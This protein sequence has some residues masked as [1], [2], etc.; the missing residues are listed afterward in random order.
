MCR[1]MLRAGDRWPAMTTVAA[2]VAA[3]VVYAG[4]LALL[5]GVRARQHLAA[6]GSS[7]FAGFTA[8]RSGWARVA[9]LTFAVALVAGALSPVLVVAGLIAVLG[10]R[11]PLFLVLAGLVV[12]LAGLVVAWRSQSAM[13]RSWRIG[14]DPA[15]RTELVTEGVFAS[16]R[17]PIF[18]GMIIAQAGVTSMAPTWLSLVGVALLVVACQLQV[19]LVEEPYL[20]GTHRTAYERYANGTGRFVPGVGRENVGPVSATRVK[21]H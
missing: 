19:R 17:N 20:K 9:G 18:T 21:A 13:G 8:S 12:A 1:W 10:G 4:G 11:T 16:V 7:G 3:F 6:T 15:D 5:F 14:V 2:A